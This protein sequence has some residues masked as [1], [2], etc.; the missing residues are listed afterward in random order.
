MTSAQPAQTLQHRSIVR[1]DAETYEEDEQEAVETDE[2]ACEV[3]HDLL[4]VHADDP[5]HPPYV[6]YEA[7]VAAFETVAKEDRC[8]HCTFLWR[9]LTECPPEE[10]WPPKRENVKIRN[11]RSAENCLE[12]AVVSDKNT[13]KGE[14]EGYIFQIQKIGD[15]EYNLEAYLCLPYSHGHDLDHRSTCRSV[16]GNCLVIQLIS[17]ARDRL[18]R[19]L[20]VSI[21]T[22]SIAS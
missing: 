3:C 6:E 19:T 15:Q 2:S 11:R 22:H 20:I 10:G 14:S 16:S 18:D 12:F 4:P 1:Q 5:L 21:V 13:K 8:L 9:A 17:R 7:S